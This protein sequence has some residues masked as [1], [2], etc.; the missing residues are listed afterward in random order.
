M[1]SSNDV[2]IYFFSQIV[3]GAEHHALE[4][5]R[6]QN[7]QLLTGLD[8]AAFTVDAAENERDVSMGP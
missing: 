6:L 2:F 7:L 3:T 8:H 4:G 1:A 5:R